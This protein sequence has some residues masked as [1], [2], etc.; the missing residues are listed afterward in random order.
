MD[1]WPVGIIKEGAKPILGKRNMLVVFVDGELK[2][3]NSKGKR[4]KVCEDSNMNVVAGVLNHPCRE[5]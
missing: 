1:V 5:Q 3:K 2:D 4:G